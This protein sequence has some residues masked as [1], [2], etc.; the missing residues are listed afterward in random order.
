MGKHRNKN[1]LKKQ[2]VE[3][4][5]FFYTGLAALSDEIQ[6]R[7]GEISDKELDIY[8][9]AS[10]FIGKVCGRAMLFSA[11]SSE[12][13]DA[14]KVAFGAFDSFFFFAF[15][16]DDAGGLDDE[17]IDAM[18]RLARKI[19]RPVP[20]EAF[21]RRLEGA[22]KDVVEAMACIIELAQSCWASITVYGAKRERN[23]CDYCVSR[24]IFPEIR[25]H[26]EELL[27]P[28]IKALQFASALDGFAEAP[29]IPI[30][31]GDGLRNL[32]GYVRDFANIE[33]PDDI[34]NWEEI[35]NNIA[36]DY[37]CAKVE[38]TALVAKGFLDAGRVARAF[39]CDAKEIDALAKS[40][41]MKRY[42]ECL[43]GKE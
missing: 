40:D 9:T 12:E 23:F 32:A 5:N 35:L 22:R 21:C 8:V 42:L 39:E 19:Y 7:R 25:D 13:K 28:R 1:R 15:N 24:E 38:V 18:S 20:A 31:R 6:K 37:S 34:E 27:L 3:E 41:G 33:N 30:D 29:Q 11:L 26:I 16:L 4:V 2:F 36:S 17:N 43:W 14:V 10:A